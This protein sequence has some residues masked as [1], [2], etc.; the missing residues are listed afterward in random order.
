MLEED[1]VRIILNDEGWDF[2][3]QM[4]ETTVECPTCG[5]IKHL[6]AP[7]YMDPRMFGGD[8]EAAR[9]EHQNMWLAIH[10]ERVHGGPAVFGEEESVPPEV[11]EELT[12]SVLPM[13]MQMAE[14]HA[15]PTQPRRRWW[16][17]W[18]RP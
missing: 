1:E 18:E 9:E 4:G 17:F 5:R 6:Q 8:L 7:A 3:A 10:E 11:A 12:S 15:L 13:L 14:I 16:K 2:A